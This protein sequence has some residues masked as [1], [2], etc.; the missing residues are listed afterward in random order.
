V[1]PERITARV[2]VEAGQKLGWE[3]YVGLRGAVV[4]LDGYGASAPY[5]DIYADL[6]ITAEAVAR[7]ATKLVG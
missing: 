1:L 3:H 5:Q 2:A 4:G 6:G 7:E